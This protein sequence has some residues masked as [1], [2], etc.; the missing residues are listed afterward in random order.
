MGKSRL[1]SELASRAKRNGVMVAVGECVPLA[2]GE[3]P[4]APIVVALR[5]LV[6]QLN[7]IELEALPGPARRELAALMPELSLVG[8]PAFSQLA[9]EGTQGRLFEHVMGVLASAAR[10]Q[11]LLLVVED[12]QW[13]DRSTR[14]FLAFLVRAARSEPIVLVVSYRS[15]EVKHRHPLR[16][17]VL[18]L[19]RSGRAIRLEL[20]PFT[21]EELREQITAILGRPPA[22][23]LVDRLL[24]RSEGNP[25]F[26]EELLA[27]S[28]ESAEPLPESIRDIVRARVDGQSSHVGDALQ[29]AAVAGRTID[30][31][32]LAVVSD[33]S[34]DD[35][36]SALRDAVE[37]YLLTHD[38]S[39]GRYSFRHALV[40]EAIYADLLPGELRSLH[41]RLAQALSEHPGLAAEQASGAA[42]LAHHWYAA[43]QLPEALAA[44]IS[45]GVA[46]E[47]LRALGEAWLHYERA[48]DIWDLAAPPADE[49]PLDRLEVLR[50]AA[51]AALLTGE[52]ARAVTL[53]RELLARINEHDAP[54]QAA[55]AYER[56]GRYLWSTGGDTDALPACRR[57]VELIPETPPSK[58]RALALAAEGQVL[59]LCDRT[60]ESIVRCEEALAI[61]RAIH[62]E[63]VEAHVLNTTCGNLC[64]AGEF[65]RAITATKQSL[66]IARRL[67]LAEELSRSYVNGSDALDESGQIEQSIATAR[68]GIECARELGFDRQWGDLLRG[69]TAGRLL[70][71]GQ[72]QEAEQLLEE[73]IN[74]S[75]TGVNA[76]MAY[77]NLGFLWTERGAF[78]AATRALDQA[79]EQIHRSAGSMMLGPPAAARASLELWANH[80][81]AASSVVSECLERVGEHEFVFFTAR[82]YELG[83]R[84]CADLTAQAPGDAKTTERQAA[85]ARKLLERLD[86]V[87]ARLTGMIPPLVRASRTA[88]AAECSRIGHAGDAVLW[89]DARRQWDTCQNRYHAAYAAFRQAEAL[90]VVGGNRADV[91]TL[92]QE[93][94]AVAD[95][96][97]ARPLLE[98][99]QSV[100]RRARIDLDDQRSAEAAVNPAL[101][102][103]ELTPRELEVL[104]L[105][106]NGLTNREIGA[107]LF[108]SNKTA[109]VHVSRILSKLSVPNRAAAAAAAQRLRV[110]PEER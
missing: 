44:S 27:S 18:E 109:S 102:T 105:L 52:E 57:A 48:L 92:V 89:A 79:A 75:P 5:S 90:L 66:E 41:L 20:R 98:Q 59:M 70:Q 65:E 61:A 6:R 34:Q 12:L 43:G 62:A 31:A 63:A 3:L 32:L 13:A 9:G 37:S 85:T 40:R 74:R 88:A 97:G 21:R 14:D 11:P 19:E 60:T 55:L 86:G 51:D 72:W 82:V 69:E 23:P 83:A 81:E 91:R 39:T 25:F 84:A 2:E 108:I 100:A 77:R 58:A 73:V 22:S 8:E 42:E 36:N 35:L 47:N 15:D 101:E 29:I 68:E 46:A 94:H 56:L 87:I 110:V 71:I 80:P 106:A 49:L 54:V 93:A 1:I 107:E 4:Y 104:A 99:L 53:A 96:L 16:P 26:A 17:F 78:D 10:A 30:H 64:A 45:A 50:R 38:S 76:G 33:L 24:E 103:L 67:D 7:A 95:D 28:R